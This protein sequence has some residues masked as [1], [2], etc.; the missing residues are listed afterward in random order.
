MALA[1]Q[2]TDVEARL[3]PRWDDARLLLTV[4]DETHAERALALLGPAAPGRSGREI[5]FV[6][7]RA[8]GAVGPEAVRRMLHRI[9]TEGIDG[10]LELIASAAAAA[11]EPASAPRSLAA[12]WDAV[13]ALLPPDWS[14]L[15]CEL[16]LT[17]TDH[18]DQ[19][20]LLT[21]PI[22]PYQTGTGKP[23]FRFRVAR[24]SGYGTAPGMVRSCLARLDAAEIPGE[25]RPLRSLS[26]TRPVE[27]QGP[28]WMIGGKQV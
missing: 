6:A 25:V 16:E 21:A 15:V 14:D 5:R 12:D 13:L 24:S 2:W 22:N 23:V 10:A 17:S 26:S 11:A 1:E 7:Q 18:V 27:T 20:A 8:G 4:A 9:D 28:V 19:G 3:D